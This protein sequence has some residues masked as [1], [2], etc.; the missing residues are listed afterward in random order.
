MKKS[1]IRAGIIATGLLA[2]ANNALAG[3]EWDLYAGADN[4]VSGCS[5]ADA[6]TYSE[7]NAQTS[8]PNVTA[9]DWTYNG[10]DLLGS[11][12]SDQY[13][14]LGHY[15]PGL[16]V[17]NS[18]NDNSHTIDSSGWV[19][20]I[21]LTFQGAAVTLSEVVLGWIESSPA[22][23]QIS[24]YAGN[25][26]VNNQTNLG[27]AEI[28][29]YADLTNHGWESIGTYSASS[30]YPSAPPVTVSVNNGSLS[31]S[32]WLISALNSTS[33]SSCG[34]TCGCTSNGW[35]GFK[36]YSVAANQPPP[37]NGGEVPEPATLLLM[38]LML[39][40]LMR[41]RQLIKT[42]YSLRA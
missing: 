9:T 1:I 21:L 15:S 34:C 38:G 5:S 36:L 32:Y 27:S 6:T 16:G 19:D 41:K 33:T 28:T 37:G 7:N 18:S 40:M 24:Y 13:P 39:P 12:G 8:A 23:F 42:T 17:M 20:S 4:C 31:S 35:S 22:E 14:E 26:G 29:S 2:M 11:T 3:W 30:P 25:D 10:H